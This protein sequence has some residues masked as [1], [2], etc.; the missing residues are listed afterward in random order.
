MKKTLSMMAPAI[1]AASIA[2][3]GA[4]SADE[5]YMT[6]ADMDSMDQTCANVS[7]NQEA[8]TCLEVFYTASTVKT[9]DILSVL[10]QNDIDKL[11]ADFMKTCIYDAI[12]TPTFTGDISPEE[13]LR[14]AQICLTEVGMIADEEN[15]EYDFNGTEYLIARMRR[16]RHLDLN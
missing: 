6:Q 7:T 5:N 3:S 1:A 15:I 2:F 16:L 4:A 9:L 14:S 8:A 11:P 13:Y 10:K 12:P